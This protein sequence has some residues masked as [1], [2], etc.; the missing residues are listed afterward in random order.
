MAMAEDG[1]NNSG[2]PRPAGYAALVARYNLD[3]IPNWHESFVATRG[4][5][6]LDTTGGVVRETYPP[7]NWPG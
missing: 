5:H 4:T 1:S 7:T 3:V 2:G 6:R